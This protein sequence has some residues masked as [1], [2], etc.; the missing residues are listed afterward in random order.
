MEKNADPVLLPIDSIS[1]IEL[2]TVDHLVIH[3]L[4]KK[5]LIGRQVLAHQSEE[6]I[7]ENPEGFLPYEVEGRKRIAT[8]AGLSWFAGRH[9]AAVNLYGQHLRIYRLEEL[10]EAGEKKMGLKLLHQLTEEIAFPEDVAVSSD[11]SLIAIS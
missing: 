3:I 9:L 4:Y 1:P 10:Y 11:C 8:C 5:S 2:K 7:L 6:S